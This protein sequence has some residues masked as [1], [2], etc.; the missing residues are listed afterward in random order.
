MVKISLY[1]LK[2]SNT[3]TF[4]INQTDKIE[5]INIINNLSINKATGPHSIPTDILH[6]IKLSVAQPLADITN[7]S[8]E[9]GNFFHVY[10]WKT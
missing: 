10:T 6:L 3:N 8:F 5:V 4:F 9:K 1:N 7:L 2:N